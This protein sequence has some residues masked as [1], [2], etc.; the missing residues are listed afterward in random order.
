VATRSAS[1][2]IDVQKAVSG[3]VSLE[4]KLFNAGVEA[5]QVY[6]NQAARFSTI[7]G[8]TLKAI[9][10]DKASMSDAVRNITAFA[11]QN[12]QAFADLSHKLSTSY[13]DELDRMAQG[14]L[15][16]ADNAGSDT[17]PVSAPANQTRGRK[18][19]RQ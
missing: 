6:V 4:L 16:S 1:N 8:D 19:M 17:K 18:R 7:A 10:D 2:A 13:Y 11:R 12:A 9:Q 14:I 3:A 15:K 5:M